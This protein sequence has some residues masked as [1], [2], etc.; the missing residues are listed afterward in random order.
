MADPPLAGPGPGVGVGPSAPR[1][2]HALPPAAAARLAPE[3]GLNPSLEARF[4]DAL[5]A[6]LP[7]GAGRLL[8]A[9]SG[10]SDSS[11]LA[12]LTAA[13]APALGLSAD[14]AHCDHGLREGSAAEAVSVRALGARLGLPV[15]ALTLEI[16]ATGNREAAARRARYAALGDLAARVGV[17]ALLTGHTADDRAET[18]W[19][20]LLRGTGP[21]GLSPL[22]AS[23]P[24]RPGSSL[25][26]LRPLLGFRR[27]ELQDY[28][29]ERDLPWLEDPSNA[30][31][32]LRRNRVRH[33][34]L[35]ALAADYGIDP[36]GNA[37]GLAEQMGELIAFL[38]AELAARGL[39]PEVLAGRSWDR[40]LLASQPP[41][42]A[43]RCLGELLARHGLLR[44]WAVER[45]LQHLKTPAMRG[46]VE[47]GEGWQIDF[48]EK[49]LA[50]EQPGKPVPAAGSPP[51]LEPAGDGTLL[52]PDEGARLPLGGGWT[53]VIARRQGNP[54]LPAGPNA[55]VFDA[56]AL[57]EPLRL[58]RPRRGLR[59]R[60]LGL[61]GSRLLSD[62]FVDRKVPR[63]LRASWP[64][65]VDARGE[66]L[67]VPG[68]ARGA[69]APLEPQTKRCLCL[70]LEPPCA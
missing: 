7:P 54:G 11:A 48:A 13:A 40:Q 17:Q 1:R 62:L 58:E 6:L 4:A 50:L 31:L 22:P 5:G 34:L 21:A 65:L 67:W 39:G 44:G 10:G 63:A 36:T 38:D 9:C 51:Q 64:L 53:L 46:I 69:S 43:R 68:L 37:L 47:L 41:V 35:P 60:P 70:D 28:L 59:I 49:T 42:L 52:P 29:R 45:L 61:G 30:D 26:V 27:A 55:A 24:L 23:R 25:L 18:L 20:W 56:D 19:L 12:A 32:S 16:P 3:P 8:L 66:L 33:R 15:H 2:Y 14:I 57:A